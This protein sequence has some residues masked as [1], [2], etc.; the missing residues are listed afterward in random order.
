MTDEEYE[1]IFTAV[2][3]RILPLEQENLETINKTPLGGD[4]EAPREP[5]AGIYNFREEPSK[6]MSCFWQFEME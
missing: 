6:K 4:D 3:H 1:E 2:L 5:I